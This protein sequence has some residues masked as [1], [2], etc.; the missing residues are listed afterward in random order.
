MAGQMKAEIGA[1]DA[2]RRE[3]EA[4]FARIEKM[5]QG[6]QAH[7]E[8]LAKSWEGDAHAEFQSRFRNDCGKLDA[9]RQEGLELC[10]FEKKAVDVY[11]GAE[12]EIE[13]KIRFL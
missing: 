4:C 8:A 1:I 13:E 2:V 3:L 11:S 5:Q 7:V 9:L 6:L 10:G 12:T